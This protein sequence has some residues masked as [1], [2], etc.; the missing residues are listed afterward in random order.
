MMAG[1]IK[2]LM[3]RTLV[4]A[5]VCWPLVVGSTT[6][7]PI[8]LDK[9]LA[10]AD[11]AIQGTFRG[12]SFKRL[13]SGEV[14]TEA[15]FT[16]VKSSGLGAN[17]IPNPSDFRIS[18]PGGTWQGVVY[19]VANS[20]KFVE[21]QEYVLLIRKGPFGHMLSNFSLGK[22]DI[23]NVD[24]ERV[25]VSS[26]FPEHSS[27]GR[28]SY[29]KFNF[30]LQNAYGQELGVAIKDTSVHMRSKNGEAALRAPSSDEEEGTSAPEDGA[31]YIIWPVL[32]LGLLGALGVWAKTWKR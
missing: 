7:V 19:H 2:K 17:D 31:L 10:E 9:Q 28:I 32:I 25:L 27:L 13:P 24:E 26:V 29:G 6:F 30:M 18:Y 4:A 8:T 5:L 12:T 16:G 20:P 23:K 11:A 3:G 15:S 14:V 22:Y 1:Q 21:G